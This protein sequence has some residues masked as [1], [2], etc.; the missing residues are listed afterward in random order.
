MEEV[1]GTDDFIVFLKTYEEA[2]CDVNP[3]T[4][5]WISTGLAALTSYSVDFDL[6]LN[7][8]VLTLTGT[9]FGATINNTVVV[10]DGNNQTIIAG[11]DTEV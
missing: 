9:N 7:D 2:K 8:Y 11:S 10:I 6:T 1:E 4:F 3:C 5:Q